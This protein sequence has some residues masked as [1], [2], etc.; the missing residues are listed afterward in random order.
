MIM[1]IDIPFYSQEKDWTCGPA[2]LRMILEKCGIKIL[3][4]DLERALKTDNKR[5]TFHRNFYSMSKKFNLKS[6]AKK[7]SSINELKRLISKNFVVIIN[8]MFNS[9][10]DHYVIVTGFYKDLFYLNDPW[11][12]KEKREK[13]SKTELEKIWFDTGGCKKWLFAVKV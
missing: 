4:K 11:T 13:I 9:E 5:G 10:D 12:G 8:M 7:N 6:V 2:C 3:E 1:K